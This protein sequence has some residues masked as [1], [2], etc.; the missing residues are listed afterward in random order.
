MTVSLDDL[1]ASL[2]DRAGFRT[3]DDFLLVGK[4]FLELVEA[5]QPTSLISSNT[6]EPH[7]DR[8]S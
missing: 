5:T 3:L 7:L 8:N 2:Q 4:A 1:Q 6:Y